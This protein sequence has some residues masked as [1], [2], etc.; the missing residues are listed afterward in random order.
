MIQ[1][2]QIQRPPVPNF[3]QNCQTVSVNVSVKQNYPNSEEQNFTSEPKQSNFTEMSEASQQ[4]Q[5][6][7]SKIHTCDICRKTFKRREHLYQHV[8][9]HTGFRP[10][11]CENC[12]KSF[13]R[14]EHVLRHM[15]SHSGQKN[16]TCTICDKSF[17][18]ND[19]LL[20]HKK[21][22][23]KQSSFTCDICQKQFVMKHY[24]LAHKM[25]HE[26]DKCGIN[27]VWGLLKT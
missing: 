7:N 22:H 16:F 11:T 13:V 9:L 21:T 10:F 17:S 3:T 2:P 5:Q 23:E 19:N 12:N 6:P 1:S 15:T 27:Q 8:K 24:Y 4:C 26:N 18:R 14:K 25:T 20:K